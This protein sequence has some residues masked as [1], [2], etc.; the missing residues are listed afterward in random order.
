MDRSLLPHLPVVLAVARHRSF[1][2]AAAELGLGASAV[3]HAVRAV[4]EFLGEP[5]FVRTT[6]SVAL[7]ASGEAFAGRL[8]QAFGEID[9]AVET[10]RAGRGEEHWPHEP[11]ARRPLEDARNRRVPDIRRLISVPSN[12]RILLI[13]TRL[14]KTLIFAPRETRGSATF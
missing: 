8:E 14:A 11:N 7:T 9:A 3:S 1:V 13:S 12:A 4:E 6:R 5:L 10:I 2:R